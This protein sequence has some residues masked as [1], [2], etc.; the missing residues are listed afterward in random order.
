MVRLLVAAYL[1][2]LAIA[3]CG[4]SGEGGAPGPVYGTPAVQTAKPTPARS[5]T[6][7]EQDPGYGY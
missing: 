5:G 6:Y 3:A 4:A 1:A 7:K 2:G